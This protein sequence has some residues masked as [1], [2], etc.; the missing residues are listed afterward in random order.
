MCAIFGLIDYGRRFSAWQREKIL[1]VLSKECEERGTDATGFAFNKAEHLTVYKRP[2]A[3]HRLR[4]R[5]PAEANIILGHT[6]MATQGS[7]ELNYNNHPFQ[8]CVGNTTF[9]LAHNGVI[10]NDH[11]LRLDKKLPNTEIGTDSYIAVQLLEQHE[12]L[13]PEAIANMAEQIEGS[14]VFTILDRCNNSYFV[15]GDNP[16]ALYHFEKFGFYIYASTDKILTRALHKLGLQKFDHT[17]IETECGD[18]L[19]IDRNGTLTRHSF[20]TANIDDWECHCFMNRHSYWWGGASS[21]TY[22]DTSAI[23][24][25][26]E[27]AENVGIDEYA[28]DM[29]LEYGYTTD[30]IEELFYVHG[31][32]ELAI[33]EITGE[34]CEI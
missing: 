16:L 10:Y 18:I 24:Q 11:T 30:D 5:L 9:A 33:M 2:F 21:A 26:K 31:G 4:L 19:K 8:G 3:A 20:N 17:D 32:I 7:K 25:L 13:T 1:K 28:I 6:R 22:N 23:K 29:L 27:F 12:T 14:F 34:R 15:K